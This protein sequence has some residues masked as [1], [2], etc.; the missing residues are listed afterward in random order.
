MAIGGIMSIGTA[1]SRF[2]TDIKKNQALKGK[3]FQE[4]QTKVGAVIGEVTGR[5]RAAEISANMKKESAANAALGSVPITGGVSFGGQA[6]K[7]TWLPFAIV[8][9]LVLIFFQPFKK[10]RR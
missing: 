4:A 9:A 8:A 10:R 7:Q 3:V 6:T 1:V 2:A 5:N